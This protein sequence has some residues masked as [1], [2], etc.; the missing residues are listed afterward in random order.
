GRQRRGK[1]DGAPVQA[2]DVAGGARPANFGRTDRSRQSADAEEA[3]RALCLGTRSCRSLASVR[4]EDEQPAAAC[5]QGTN[6]STVRFGSS[7]GLLPRAIK[8]AGPVRA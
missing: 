2:A 5:E 1:D 3:R 4:A 6:G 7:V 8:I